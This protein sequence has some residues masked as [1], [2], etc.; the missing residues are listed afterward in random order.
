MPNEEEKSSELLSAEQVW[1]VVSFARYLNG[2]NS[3]ITP[4]SINARMK[5]I[6]LN[7]IAATEALLA[8]AMKDPKNNEE[9]LQSISQFLELS[10]MVYKRLISYSANMLAFDITYTSNAKADEYKL[11]KYKKD[12]D[13][14]ESFL[15][16]F[17]FRNEFRAAVRGML[18]S[19]A[20]FAAFYDLGNKYILQ[21]LPSDYCKI[22]GRWEGGLLF[23]FDFTWFEQPGVDIS[24]YPDWFKKKYIE[25][26][27]KRAALIYE[28]S[29]YKPY[30]P[31]EKRGSSYYMMWVDVPPEVGACFKFAPEL[32]T[33]LPYFT[34]LFNDLVL[35]PA[36]RALQQNM[37]MAEAS[38]MIIGEVPLLNK[39]AKATVKDSIAISPDLLGK[40]LAL[41]K[42][43]ISE[44]VKLSAAPLQ[45][46]KSIDF[47]GNNEMY[48]KYVRTTLALSG[49]NT[50]LIFSSDVKPNVI[51]TQLSLNVDE[52]LMCAL[53]EQFEEY[54]GYQI[55]LRTKSFKFSFVFE[56]TDF[57]INRDARF[58]KAMSLFDKGIVLPQK[59]A[60]A[61]R[62]K[63]SEL[64]KHM[65]EA[66]ANDF[67]GLLTPPSFMQ[68]KE[69]AD[70][71]AKNTKEVTQINIDAQKENAKIAADAASKAAETKAKESD[72]GEGA[73]RPQKEATAL[74][75]EGANTRASGAN[76]ARG[77]KV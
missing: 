64:R 36:V 60:A 37:N 28:P 74:T 4:D 61:L 23:S 7:P 73:G 26:D 27:K 67:M 33:R 77:G 54:L 35:Q 39:E 45:N 21:E 52:Q 41:V 59:I 3:F 18:R 46:F 50:N 1:D 66:K 48:D 68:Q 32:A 5:Q 38:K 51:E 24:M 9:T 13:I 10:T 62:M 40:F 56:G 8:T 16:K 43:G 53:Y 42:S 29:T 14:V 12:L 44:S 72:S 34:P 69:M 57:S 65:E 63:P 22:T 76:I 25:L 75:D 19:D 17:E 49:V 47:E 2:Y 71:N 15:D 11:P 55:N 30:L 70:I 31:V 6:N 20:Y 58:D